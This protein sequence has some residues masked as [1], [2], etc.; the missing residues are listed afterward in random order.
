MPH[1]NIEIDAAKNLLLNKPTCMNCKYLGPTE[2]EFHKCQSYWK[3]NWKISILD[4]CINWIHN[5]KTSC[6]TEFFK[7]H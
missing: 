5:S 4:T 3:F 7:K 2:Q 6:G 1:N